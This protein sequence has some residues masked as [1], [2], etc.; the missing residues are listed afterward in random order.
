MI[1]STE[2]VSTTKDMKYTSEHRRWHTEWWDN[3]AGSVS[4]VCLYFAS[5]L[6]KSL[7]SSHTHRNDLLQDT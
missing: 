5:L 3:Y 1:F 4:I 7:E 6:K 2:A